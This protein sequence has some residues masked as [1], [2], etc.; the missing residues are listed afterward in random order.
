MSLIIYRY[1]RSILFGEI[2]NEI[3]KEFSKDFWQKELWQEVSHFISSHI[4][5]E[6]SFDK[7]RADSKLIDG[8]ILLSSKITNYYWYAD[9]MNLDISY[10]FEFKNGDIP[11]F[12][13]WNIQFILLENYSEFQVEEEQNAW[14]L[15]SNFLIIYK[16][17]LEDQQEKENSYFLSYTEF[18][19]KLTAW[20]LIEG[21]KQN[22][23]ET[24]DKKGIYLSTKIWISM[25]LTQ[26]EDKEHLVKFYKKQINEEHNQN[27]MSVEK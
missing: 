26:L 20:D 9:P 1:T 13:Y 10:K 21:Y 25:F 2:I 15:P 7:I 22:Y 16:T 27:E 3:T 18:L 11:G 12:Q 6:L 19:I 4:G 17:M 5:D 23:K 14:I 24:C 8:L